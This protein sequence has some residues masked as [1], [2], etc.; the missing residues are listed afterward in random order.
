MYDIISKTEY[1][2][3]LDE[4]VNAATPAPTGTLKHIQD[5]FILSVL[6]DLKG[7]KIL[8]FGGGKSRILKL[9]SKDN[10]CWNVD[11]F[12][13]ADGGPARLIRQRKVKTVKAYLGDFN[14]GIPSDYFDY[15]VSISVAE[16]IPHGDLE[17]VFA[18]CARVLRPGGNLVQ[19]IDLYLPD[20]TDKDEKAFQF[21]RSRVTDYLRAAEKAGLMLKEPAE[22]E[23]DAY[24]RGFHASNSDATL[25]HW[26]SGAPKLRA[27][28]ERGQS[29]SLK[30]WW[31][32]PPTG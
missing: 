11:K 24:F 31:I 18:D 29:V 16:H 17:R 3:W 8:E 32:K 26:N 20:A 21:N 30:S 19:A 2:Q 13:G 22:V 12:E 7:K 14:D 10:E 1:W 28:R 25:F 23:G 9:L 5:T 4:K 27:T 6:K 15:V